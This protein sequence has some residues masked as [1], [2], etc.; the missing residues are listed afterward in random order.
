MGADMRTDAGTGDRAI[1]SAASI[2]QR[3]DQ[4]ASLFAVSANGVDVLGV[5]GTNLGRSGD[6]SEEEGASLVFD[7]EGEAD[8]EEDSAQSWRQATVNPPAWHLKFNK[9]SGACPTTFYLREK[10]SSSSAPQRRHRRRSD[11][12]RNHR[13]WRYSTGGWPTGPSSRWAR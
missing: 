12:V 7:S 8:G 1:G 11:R 3:S 10:A 4:A 2:A 6:E 13:L 5:D 9:N